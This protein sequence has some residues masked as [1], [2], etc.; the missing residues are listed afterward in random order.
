MAAAWVFNPLTGVTW[1]NDG[2]VQ[3]DG[4]GDYLHLGAGD[5]T[6]LDNDKLT[7]AQTLE[8]FVRLDAPVDGDSNVG[9]LIGKWNQI[10]D[11]GDHLALFVN[12]NGSIQCDAQSAA[13]GFDTTHNAGAGGNLN[14]QQWHHVAAVYVYDKPSQKA[15]VTVYQDYKLSSGLY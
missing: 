6:D 3:C 15:T 5:S 4:R 1:Q 12:G 9:L 14:D 13:G 2:A 8:A 11:G 10:T 7:E